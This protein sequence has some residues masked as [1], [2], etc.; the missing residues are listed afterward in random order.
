VEFGRFQ[1]DPERRELRIGGEPVALGSRA[2]DVMRLLVEA[3]GGLVTK[4]EIMGRVWPGAIVEENTLQVTVSMLR[5]TLGPYRGAV[6]T[7]SGRGYQLVA[8]AAMPGQAN[9][10]NLHAPTSALVGRGEALMDVERLVGQHRI[11]TLTGV[12]GIGK[13]RLG[14]EAARRLLPQFADGVWVAELAAL[15]DAN[16]VAHRIADTL[17]LEIPDNLASPSRISGLIRARK[18]LLVLDNCEHV[19]DVVAELVET[20]TRACP[21]LRVLVTSREP[22]RMEGEGL[23]RVAPL[24][25]PPADVTLPDVLLRHG[26]VELFV[27]CARAVG[28]A[29]S[30][31]ASSLPTIAAICRRLDGIP[32]AIELAAARAATL[33]VDE[34][35]R[36]LDD[37][38]RVLTSGFRTALPRHRTL[39][40][41]FDW[42]FDLLDERER[43]AVACLAVL[44]GSFALA[45]AEAI[46]SADGNPAPDAVDIVSSL[47]A[48]SLVVA[49]DSSSGMHYRLLETTRGYA[50]AKLKESGEFDCVAL[51]HAQYCRDLLH[52]VELDWQ[53]QAAEN[54]PPMLN[55]LA[56]NVRTAIDW[57]YS[58][59]GDAL[60]AVTLAAAAAPLW[61]HLSMAN[62]CSQQIGRALATLDSLPEHEPR[63]DMR[64]LTAQGLAL[65]STMSAGPEARKV[66]EQALE[67]AERL[68]DGDYRLRSLWGVC[69]A[70]FNDGDFLRAR[71]AARRFHELA[72]ASGDAN[73]LVSGDLLLGGVLLTMADYAGARALF[74]R[75][76]AQPYSTRDQTSSSRFLFN[77]RVLALGGLGSTLWHLGFIDQS[78]RKLEESVD[79]ALSNNHVLSLCA[80][81]ANWACPIAL[82]RGDLPA[83]ERA[84]EILVDHATRYELAFWLIWGRCFRG[85]LTV[86]QG[87]LEGGLRQLRAGLAELPGGADHPRFTPWRLQLADALGCTGAFDEALGVID[88]GLETAEAKGQLFSLPEF[89]RIRGEIVRRRG[90]PGALE[91]AAAAFSKARDIAHRQGS[92]STELRAATSLA[93]LDLE[94]GPRNEALRSL[95]DVYGRFSE[96]F[97]TA[98]L[99]AARALLSPSL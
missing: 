8:E 26:A 31:D 94:E 98:D 23:Y 80:T 14:L 63:L 68:E 69:S 71:D 12:G 32:L 95:A 76:D 40:A 25:V 65:L 19:I 86:R 47:V 51:R 89:T 44:V 52:C 43:Y 41:T 7:V 96:G 88:K 10:T 72:T 66:F 21:H 83:A 81:L 62:E 67:I 2:Y 6:R 36:R 90:G 93:Q 29:F 74:E 39:K 30:V 58:S 28:G 55:D 79:E 15:T 42:S 61:M 54:K 33:G 4:D 97:E 60:L 70:C 24:S 82:F 46:V 27:T 92:L 37:Q 84:L 22:L 49:E 45:T 35:A 99:L 75:I 91:M 78:K 18:L 73:A 9:P 20:L 57:A 17:E 16:S 38:F 59:A 5:K 56:G 3:Q 13:T 85:A 11:V 1:I 64:L 87:D 48:K 77:R 34:L 53:G 50:L